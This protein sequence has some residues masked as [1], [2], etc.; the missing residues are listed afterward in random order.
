MHAPSQAPAFTSMFLDASQ[1]RLVAALLLCFALATVFHEARFRKCAFLSTPNKIHMF[2]AACGVFVVALGYG[3]AG[4]LAFI[5]PMLLVIALRGLIAKNRRVA[6]VCVG[7]LFA[8]LSMHQ[9]K[10]ACFPAATYQITYN[11]ALMV[12]TST[13]CMFVIDLA[14][15]K[16][17][18]NFAI[19]E[20]L[21]MV[22]HF[23]TVLAGPNLRFEDYLTCVT[24]PSA[25]AKS[26]AISPQTL[27]SRIKIA[28][29]KRLCH[30]LLTAAIFVGGGKFFS[31]SVLLTDVFGRA[32]L[33]RK[34]AIVYAVA[35]V[36]RS[37]YYFAWSFA[38][39]CATMTGVAARVDPITKRLLFDRVSNVRILRVE[40]ATSLRELITNWNTSTAAWLYNYVYVRASPTGKKP[41][42]KATLAT[43]LTSAVWHGFHVGYYWTFLS[44]GVASFTMRLWY[45]KTAAF[46]RTYCT[47]PVVGTAAW[48][49][50]IVFTQFLS[51]SL[52][53]PFL[54]LH[55]RETVAYLRAIRCVPHAVILLLA[56]AS[57]LVPRPPQPAEMALVVKQRAVQPAEDD[58]AATHAKSH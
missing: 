49:L 48:L 11:G 3:V 39:A 21:G 4:V 7:V 37:K 38:E 33:L 17:L 26:L 16:V 51:C 55:H 20:F 30:S 14:D 53:M 56:A 47:G 35:V 9:I 36:A 19:V 50:S 2:N 15:G 43:N 57:F 25:I 5:F 31:P 45:R 41:G 40:F 12:L 32:S 42:F 46:T 18:A 27:S 8:Y 34:F 52:L 23:P 13:L 24:A 6:H 10:N 58:S 44:A 28:A 1:L 54:L 29:C 22:F